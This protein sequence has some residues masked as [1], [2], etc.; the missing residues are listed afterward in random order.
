MVNG[1]R[2]ARGIAAEA[3]SRALRRL[4]VAVHSSST[5]MMRGPH[6]RPGFNLAGVVLADS[7]VI[8]RVAEENDAERRTTLAGYRQNGEAG[9]VAMPADGVGSGWP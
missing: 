8:L 6:R 9:N 3:G 7:N 5:P 2:E 4:P 1:V